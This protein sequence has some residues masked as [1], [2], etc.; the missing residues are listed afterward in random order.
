MGA[1]DDK[2]TLWNIGPAPAPDPEA[3]HRAATTRKRAQPSPPPRKAEP[4]VLPEPE[5]GD[6][7][8]V[9]AIVPGTRYRLLRFLGDGGMG[10]V[11]EAE[12]VDLERK[13]ALKV[14]LPALCRA[15]EALAMFRR[16][17]RTA[18]K[19]GAEQIVGVFDFAELP[20]RR[21]LFAME[22]LDGPTV[23]DVVA[24]GPMPATRVTAILRQVCKGLSAAHAAGVVH[25]DIKPENIVLVKGRDGRPDTVKILDFGISTILDDES[26]EGPVSAGTPYYLAPEFIA[27]YEF[28]GHMDQYALGCTA[29]E[30][31]CGHPPFRAGDGEGVAE[32]LDQHLR[33]DPPRLNRREAGVSVPPA[34]ERVVLRCLAKDP[35]DRY[36][37]MDA[38]EAA[39]CE[40][41]VD[42]KLMT[43]WDDLPLP[44]DI[45]P[46]LRDKLLRKMPDPLGPP[47][48]RT[49]STLLFG[50]LAVGLGAAAMYYWLG[51]DLTAAET[52]S[53]APEAPAEIAEAPSL[54]DQLATE[55]RTAAARSYFVIPPAD[56]PEQ[57]TAYRKLQELEEIDGEEKTAAQQQ[58][59]ELRKELAATLVRLGDQYWD[60]EGGRPFAVDYY[61][62]A[63]LFVRDDPVA[64]ERSGLTPDQLEEL[65]AKAAVGNFSEEE[66]LEAESLVALA[67]P[68]LDKRRKKIKALRKRRKS[69]G[70][71]G[72]TEKLLAVGE[73][74]TL[75]AKIGDLPPTAES[76][77]A[78]D[79]AKTGRKALGSGKVDEARTF[80]DRAL[81]FDVDNRAALGGMFDLE[82]S[83]GNY[84]QAVGFAQRLV[85]A[86]P[87]SA[88]GHVKLGDAYFELGSLV[89]ARAA[90]YKANGM[91]N[92]R[93]KKKLAKVEKQIGPMPVPDPPPEPEPEPAAESDDT[94][95]KAEGGDDQA[96]EKSEST[97]SESAKT[98]PAKDAKPA[99][100]AKPDDGAAKPEPAADDAVAKS[101]EPK[102]PAKATESAGAPG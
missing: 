96:P 31:L 34:L 27:G 1:P 86:H 95:P 64:S 26:A 10:Q 83:R 36:R 32:I 2:R 91:G 77:T 28:D 17:A 94:A 60:R 82:F 70:D 3:A 58:A 20:D 54:V 61:K 6:R 87:G 89:Q 15:P 80:F 68:D 39:L 12:H 29:Y 69:R 85:A 51:R 79:L 21:L 102:P 48:R 33:A 11:Y 59:L 37:D 74:P 45:D 99:D 41:Q 30:M 43:S 55:A 97:K 8:E 88:D 23:A 92:K 49:G 78:T 98:E 50:A 62:Q 24:E 101:D 40:A 35:D 47:R 81:T 53:D 52:S 71:N 4:I 5:L 57:T 100:A 16:E 84:R 7:F 42:A 67:E 9:G 25:R 75:P 18:S 90:Y 65:E 72:A 93:A 44:Q 56:D 66:L 19:V 76:N 63:L 38:L 73:A 14:L 22:L 46:A 13:V